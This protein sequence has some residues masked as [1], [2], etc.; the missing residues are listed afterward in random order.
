MVLQ[1]P[2]GNDFF[3]QFAV[4]PLMPS[5]YS[6]VLLRYKENKAKF[7]LYLP[8]D[9]ESAGEIFVGALGKLLLRLRITKME[10]FMGKVFAKTMKARL[11]AVAC[12]F[13]TIKYTFTETNFWL[14]AYVCIHTA[15]PHRHVMSS[16]LG[17]GPASIVIC[18]STEN[19]IVV[20]L[21]QCP[22]PRRRSGR[23]RCSPA[24]ARL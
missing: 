15:C 24:P 21:V 18:W 1:H 5:C 16:Y 9:T 7:Q 13:Y 19:R 17:L 4:S 23:R 12:F 20:F 10:C 3:Q 22:R 2:S 11:L 14:G 8:E 6:Q